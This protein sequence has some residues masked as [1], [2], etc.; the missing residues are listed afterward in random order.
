MRE[1]I[2][3]VWWSGYELWPPGCEL[4]ISCPL[5]VGLVVLAT[6]SSTLV[7]PSP[8]RSPVVPLVLL[9]IVVHLWVYSELSTSCLLPVG[10]VV[11]V[12]LVVVHLWVYSELSISCP[13][14][15]G[16]VVLATCS[17]TLVGL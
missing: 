11:L 13:L 3:G 2:N 16:L 15:V 7:G 12:L 14:P 5:P 8:S 6:C 10:L 1:Q 17:S 9:L 4:S